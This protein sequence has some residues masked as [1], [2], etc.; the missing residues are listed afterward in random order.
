MIQILRKAQKQQGD[1]QTSLDE[2]ERTPLTKEQK[3]ARLKDETQKKQ[4]LRLKQEQEE[5]QKKKAQEEEEQKKKRKQTS[6]R[7]KEEETHLKDEDT[8]QKKDKK[9][10]EDV[11]LKRAQLETAKRETEEKK[12][13]TADKKQKAAASKEKQERAQIV[14]QGLRSLSQTGIHNMSAVDREQFFALAMEYKA[15]ASTGAIQ[16]EQQEEVESMLQ[17][18]TGLAS[19]KSEVNF[20]LTKAQEERAEKE[21]KNAEKMADFLKSFKK[22]PYI[23]YEDVDSFVQAVEEGHISADT[24]VTN[25]QGEEVTLRTFTREELTETANKAISAIENYTKTSQEYKKAVVS[26]VAILFEMNP[27]DVQTTISILATHDPDYASD[28][29]KLYQRLCAKPQGREIAARFRRD[30][31]LDAISTDEIVVSRFSFIL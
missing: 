20:Y 28:V 8:K 5:Q 7:K 31:D 12:A 11:A 19:D 21:R 14:V 18:L 22:N 27:E 17:Q 9:K 25:A 15:L 1:G 29:Q 23:I 26:T 6:L 4:D 30:N 16:F 2:K 13:V 10:A 24:I 3:E